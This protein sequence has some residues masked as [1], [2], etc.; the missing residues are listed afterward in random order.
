MSTGK[1]KRMPPE[2]I[3]GY[4]KAVIESYPREL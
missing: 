1:P 4:G 2:F 3:E